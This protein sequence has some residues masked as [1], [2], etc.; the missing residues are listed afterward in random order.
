MTYS[1]IW[2]KTRLRPVVRNLPERIEAGS[3]R[4]QELKKDALAAEAEQRLASTG[5]LPEMLRVPAASTAVPEAIAA[6]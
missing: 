1:A 4:P 5:W 6:E 2:P 3:R